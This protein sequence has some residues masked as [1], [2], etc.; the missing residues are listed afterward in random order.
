LREKHF[1]HK[2]SAF[3]KKVYTVGDLHGMHQT[4]I[5]QEFVVC[6]V[7]QGFCISIQTNQKPYGLFLQPTSDAM[8]KSIE[9]PYCNAINSETS[10]TNSVKE[11]KLR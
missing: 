11:G 5:I 8:H 7:T 4:W 2:V 9:N 10:I 3:G 1:I 6:S